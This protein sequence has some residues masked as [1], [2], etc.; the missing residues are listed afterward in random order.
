MRLIQRMG[1]SERNQEKGS[2]RLQ[3]QSQ[4][5]KEERGFSMMMPKRIPKE[6]ELCTS[7]KSNQSEAGA[8][9]KTQEI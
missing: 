6:Q 7:L 2:H 3:E 5:R 8:D 1:S 9:E 4:P